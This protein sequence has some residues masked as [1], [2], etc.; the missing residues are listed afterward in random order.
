MIYSDLF[1]HFGGSGGIDANEGI[2][3]E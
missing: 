3:N 2:A 1:L